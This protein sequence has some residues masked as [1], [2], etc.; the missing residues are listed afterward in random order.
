MQAWSE[1]LY[2][3]E[4]ARRE[5][6]RRR[7][8]GELDVGGDD[9]AAEEEA[10]EEVEEEKVRVMLKAKDEEPLRST[11]RMTTTVETLVTLYRQ[12][13]QVPSTKQVILM[14]DGERLEEHMTIELAEISDMDS[15][16]VL[17]K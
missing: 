8:M 2:E 9:A 11:V 4:Q 13:R 1:E 5:K 15:I 14:F 7:A 16:D 17:V 10:A 6:E 3:K 12:Q